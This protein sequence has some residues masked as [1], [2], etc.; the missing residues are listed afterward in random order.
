M[1]IYYLLPYLDFILTLSGL[2]SGSTEKKP[3]R[4]NWNLSYTFAVLA[5]LSSI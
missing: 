2:L 4:S 3:I 5:K 1:L